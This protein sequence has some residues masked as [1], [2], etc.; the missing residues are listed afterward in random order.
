MI[1]SLRRDSAGRRAIVIDLLVLAAWWRK[2]PAKKPG[3]H[4]GLFGKNC[5][6]SDRCAGS[7]DRWNSQSWLTWMQRL[8][9]NSAVHSKISMVI[10]IYRENCQQRLR[11]VPADPPSNWNVPSVH[12][13]RR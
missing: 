2:A 10:L 1:L 9:Q 11:H 13:Q 3:R 4:P 7:K 12:R 8:V 6:S 5:G